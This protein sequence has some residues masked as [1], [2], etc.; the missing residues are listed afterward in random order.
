MRHG[1][2][3]LAETLQLVKGAIK[4]GI[5]TQDIDLL[6]EQFILSHPGATPGFKGYHG[7][8]AT[9]CTSV[10]DDVVHGIP[11]DSVIL[12]DGDIVG[13]DCG[14]V[15]KGLYTDACLTVPVGDVKPEV[16]HF[17]K[18]T[19]KALSNALKKVRPGAYTGDL[20]AVIQK[21]LQEQGYQPVV[22]CTGHGVGVQLHEPPE[23]LNAG[24]RGTGALIQAGMTLAVEPISAM[25]S[26]EVI[27]DNDGWTV[28]TADGSLSAHFE[29]TILVTEN[30]CE[31]LA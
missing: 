10:N 21:T 18:I 2:K 13:V 7:F 11:K 1:G 19:S 12:R 22:E 28:K 30:G 25:N 31:I 6:A 17:V 9:L 8:P 14:V 24:L 15:Y 26:G 23:I 3:I 16:L 20:S 27:T 29:H 4:P 5:S